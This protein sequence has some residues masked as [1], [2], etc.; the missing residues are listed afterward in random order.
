MYSIAQQGI[1][2]ADA[3]A[4][5]STKSRRVSAQAFSPPPC[6]DRAALSNGTTGRADSPKTLPER[7][8]FEG[9]GEH[10]GAPQSRIGKRKRAIPA[11]LQS[12]LHRF[13]SGRRLSKIPAN[14]GDLSFWGSTKVEKGPERVGGALSSELE[15]MSVSAACE[16]RQEVLLHGR[17]ERLALA[18]GASPTSV[19]CA[20]QDGGWARPYAG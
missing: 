19:I 1:L 17:R 15:L 3:D 7:R 20:V 11:A 12:R 2:C 4:S 8:F 6:R 5:K 9:I 14:A 18:L 13:D 10:L 16:Q